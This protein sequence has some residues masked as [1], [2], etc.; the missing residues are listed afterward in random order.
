M[1]K[2]AS[3]F[4]ALSLVTFALATSSFRATWLIERS[5]LDRAVRLLH[6]LFIERV[7]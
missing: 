7:S 4:A 6:E 1:K 3:S 5:Q 2:A